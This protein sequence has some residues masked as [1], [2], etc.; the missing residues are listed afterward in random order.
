MCNSC[1]LLAAV[2]LAFSCFGS[3]PI[4]IGAED[5]ACEDAK[6][7]AGML[8]CASR[9]YSNADEELNLVY[10]QLM[11]K[12]AAERRGP[13]RDAQKAWIEFRDKNAAFVASD[14]EGGSLYPVIEAAELT[15]MT[16]RRILELK[17]R[18]P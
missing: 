10:K 14:V 4:A 9:R 18:L 16:K 15:E 17:E 3:A 8:D 6:T 7:T 5:P 13:L 2:L 1:G 12:L 11:S